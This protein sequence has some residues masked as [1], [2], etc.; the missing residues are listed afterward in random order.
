MSAKAK[1]LQ[2]LYRRGKVT[3]EGLK[4]AVLD[5]VITQ[6]EFIQIVGVQFE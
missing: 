6:D 2:S 3:V 4:Q 1:I 5:N